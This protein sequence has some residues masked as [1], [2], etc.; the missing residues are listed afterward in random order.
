MRWY[1][2]Y[3]YVHGT[4][5]GIVLL[6]PLGAAI[7]AA[8]GRLRRRAGAASR[9]VRRPPEAGPDAR[10]G[11]GWAAA[12]LCWSA[13]VALLVIPAATVDFDYRYV[14]PAAPLGCLAA[15]L[16][17]ASACRGRPRTPAGQRRWRG[18]YPAAASIRVNREMTKSDG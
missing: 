15:A 1:Q 11:T 2:R 16:A 14:L 13:A 3:V 6:T 8:A 12:W 17:T 18:M 4:L 7:G 5:T 10:F 9:A